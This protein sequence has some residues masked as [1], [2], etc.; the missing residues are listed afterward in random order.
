MPFDSYKDS[1][2]FQATPQKRSIDF[3]PYNKI[4]KV[5]CLLG[6]VDS[7]V[8]ALCV[9]VC[10][11]GTDRLLESSG[12]IRVCAHNN[13]SAL[14]GYGISRVCHELYGINTISMCY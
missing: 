5:E 12:V 8:V 9:S 3:Q 7:L 1:E 4:V 11:F 13:Y 6:N 14:V 10:S 2:A